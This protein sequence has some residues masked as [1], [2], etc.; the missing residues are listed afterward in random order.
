MSKRDDDK[1]DADTQHVA[2]ATAGF[3]LTHFVGGDFGLLA[4]H[5]AP[6]FRVTP[7]GRAKEALTAVPCN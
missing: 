3:T 7:V 2:H 4:S 6:H 1:E 5:V